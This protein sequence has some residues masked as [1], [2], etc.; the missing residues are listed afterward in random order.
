MPQILNLELDG[1]TG[2]TTRQRLD[3]VEFRITVTWL[4]EVARAPFYDEST[5]PPP[6]AIGEPGVW[7]LTLAQADGT[8][9]ISGQAMRNGVDVLR[10]FVGDSR[11]P[12]LGQGRLF[13]WDDSSAGL[14]PG[15]DDLVQGSPRQLIYQTA[16]EAAA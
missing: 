5:P 3:G 14:D 11:F 9:L 13:A 7:I 8:V 6:L 12:G 10:P 16:A 15:R 4:P 2:T 1:E